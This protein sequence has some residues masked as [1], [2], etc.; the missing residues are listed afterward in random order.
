MI[1]I[2]ILLN[3]WIHFSLEKVSPPHWKGLQSF[4]T[5]LSE[6]IVVRYVKPVLWFLGGLYNTL[7][8][9]NKKRI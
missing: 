2:I 6:I 9:K 4:Q 7:I 5:V 3:I 1:I 8:N